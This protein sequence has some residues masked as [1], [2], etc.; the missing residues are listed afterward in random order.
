MSYGDNRADSA[1]L[2]NNMAA[3]QV[4]KHQLKTQVLSLQEELDED[5]KICNEMM[6]DVEEV[7]DRCRRLADLCE[8]VERQNTT[9]TRLNTASVQ[10]AQIQG[11]AQL[12]A[13]VQ[14]IIANLVG[15]EE[16]ALFAC[17]PQ[18]EILSLLWSQGVN[19]DSFPA[20]PVGE[21]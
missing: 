2:A 15:C 9:L 8:R 3:L 7:Q 10:M 17:L 14:D 11:L 13:A 19:A 21:G 20:I 16:M 18:R 1:N 6:R 4:K 5:R 12:Y